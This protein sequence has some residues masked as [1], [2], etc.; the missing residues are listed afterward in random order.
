MTRW[1][2]ASLGALSLVVVAI[3]M[4]P[5]ADGISLAGLFSD[6]NGHLFEADIDAIATEGITKGCNPPAN[7]HF[8]PDDDIDRGQMAAFLRRALDLPA[9]GTDHFVDDDTSIFEGDINAIAAAGIT[10]GC[11]PPAND[12]YCPEDD[13]DRGQMAAFLRRALDL[14]TSGTDHF[15][16][17]DTSTFEGDI[18]TI[19]ADGITR[20]CNPPSNT[21]YCPTRNVTRG[22]MAA[23]LK[24]GLGLPAVIH[25]IPLGHHNAM[26]CSKDGER[27]TLTVDLSAGRRYRVQDG[28]FRVSDAT[29]GEENEFDASNTR[30]TLT[31]DGSTVSMGQVPLQSGS[32]VTNR[33][34][35]TDVTFS[36]GTH[37][38]V[39][40]WRWAGEMIQTTTITVRADG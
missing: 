7:S 9:S 21:R 32:G 23:F 3:F 6:D 18:D 15:V 2:T 10:L 34:W 22:E 30:F 31:L 27:C 24:R 16:D 38:L 29:Q 5:Q 13:V 40:T 8:C 33:Y 20:G 11:N 12:R 36:P 14:P 26:T 25:R 39:G 4:S 1:L 17:D 19:A 37:T 28:L 35:R